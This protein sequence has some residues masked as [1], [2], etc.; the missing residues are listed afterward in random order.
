MIA[1]QREADQADFGTNCEWLS[2]DLIALN[3]PDCNGNVAVYHAVGRKGKVGYAAGIRIHMSATAASEE[4]IARTWMLRTA[5][6][7]GRVEYSISA[8]IHCWSDGKTGGGFQ[9]QGDPGWSTCDTIM[10]REHRWLE[11]QAAVISDAGTAS[12]DQVAAVAGEAYSR[13]RSDLNHMVRGSTQ[14]QLN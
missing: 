8:G 1:R 10:E 9:T 3:E 7:G 4:A 2:R 6:S 5:L 13:A 11:V 12:E 14:Q